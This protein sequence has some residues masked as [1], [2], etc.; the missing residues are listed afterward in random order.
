MVMLVVHHFL[1]YCFWLLWEFEIKIRFSIIA[2]TLQCLVLE[3]LQRK[4][5]L[6]TSLVAQW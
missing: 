5:G 1:K 3:C 4:G 6:G 2:G